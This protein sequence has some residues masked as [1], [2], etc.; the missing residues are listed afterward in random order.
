MFGGV[1][2]SAYSEALL[3]RMTAALLEKLEITFLHQLTFAV[4]RL[5]QFVG[6]TENLRFG[7][8]SL[9]SMAMDLR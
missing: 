4:P 1:R 8:A 7:S 5:Q 3:L 9:C 2:L 6:A